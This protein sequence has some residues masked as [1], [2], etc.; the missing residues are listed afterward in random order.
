MPSPFAVTPPRLRC[1]FSLLP[2]FLSRQGR[3]RQGLR[4]AEFQMSRYA[5]SAAQLA[6]HADEAA[7]ATLSD[8]LSSFCRHDYFAAIRHLPLMLLFIITPLRC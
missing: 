4:Y 8:W 7:E 6:S 2:G 3:Y 5:I 1:R